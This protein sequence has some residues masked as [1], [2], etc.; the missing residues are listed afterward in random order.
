MPVQNDRTGHAFVVV[1]ALVLPLPVGTA[2]LPGE[3]GD[4]FKAL[5]ASCRHCFQ[6]GQP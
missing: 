3:R 5:C 6:R 1:A 2:D 4:G